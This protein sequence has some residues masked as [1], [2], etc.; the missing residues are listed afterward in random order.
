MP[1]KK[2]TGQFVVVGA[3]IGWAYDRWADRLPGGAERAKRLGVLLASGLIVGE[4]LFGVA[5]AA[6]IVVSGKSEPLALVG[7]G[8]ATAGEVVGTLAFI[9]VTAALYRWIAAVSRAG[10]AQ[11]VCAAKPDY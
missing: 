11:P 1:T 6:L 7:D 10:G 8:F 4:S 5:L 3:V 9:A 2:P